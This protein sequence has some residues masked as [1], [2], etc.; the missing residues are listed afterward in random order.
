MLFLRDH[1]DRLA[2]EQQRQHQFSQVSGGDVVI[3]EL[4]GEFGERRTLGYGK[5]KMGSRVEW[6]GNKDGSGIR[7]LAKERKRAH[8]VDDKGD[9]RGA[10]LPLPPAS[11]PFAAAVLPSN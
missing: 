3:H 9:A 6:K 5:S 8:P 4:T 10:S 11:F 2:G 7:E 1:F